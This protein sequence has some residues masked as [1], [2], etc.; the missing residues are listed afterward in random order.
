MENNYDESCNSYSFLSNLAK[1]SPAKTEKSQ[2][3]ISPSFKE[4]QENDLIPDIEEI[5]NLNPIKNNNQ[6]L[7]NDE[8]NEKSEQY[9]E[10]SVSIPISPE[11]KPYKS[12]FSQGNSLLEESKISHH[13][14]NIE[15]IENKCKIH[16]QHNE[17]F[18]INHLVYLCPECLREKKEEHEHCKMKSA[19]IEGIPTI[20]DDIFIDFKEFYA[21][22]YMKIEKFIKIYMALDEKKNKISYEIIINSLKDKDLQTSL[23]SPENASRKSFIQEIYSMIYDKYLQNL[24]EMHNFLI[25]LMEVTKN[26]LRLVKEN[27]ED[28]LN[29]EILNLDEQN[30]IFKN[31]LKN[32]MTL[33]KLKQ[34]MKCYEY[35]QLFFMISECEVPIACQVIFDTTIMKHLTT[36]LKKL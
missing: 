27:Y 9:N 11:K 19:D 26:T 17:K 14:I 3:F 29:H 32:N 36:L 4:N 10:N 18:C 8:S 33:I 22:H 34:D 15:K 23:N 6:N 30:M 21:F 25:D 28:Y 24:L 1:E 5:L 2:D 31:F 7:Q 20:I 16:Q 13:I 35:K 12:L